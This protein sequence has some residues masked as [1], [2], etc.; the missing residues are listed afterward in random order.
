MRFTLTLPFGPSLG[1]ELLS[2]PAVSCIARAAEEA[3]FYAAGAVD[4]PIPSGAWLRAG[5][6]HSP[7]PTL[8][9]A[10][11]AAAT[12]ALRLQTTVYILPYRNPFLT[13][14]SVATLDQLSGGRLD[15]GVGIGYQE[16]E[17]RALGIEPAERFALF[18]EALRTMRAVWAHTTVSVTGRHFVAK[19]NGAE[20]APLQQPHP[21]LWIGGVS[22]WAL[23]RVVAHG[24]AWMAFTRERFSE[25]T[26]ARLEDGIARLREQCHEAGRAPMRISVNVLEPFHGEGRDAHLAILRRLAA[27][28]VTDVRVHVHEDTVAGWLARIEEHAT[29]IAAALT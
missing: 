15:L 28:G 26:F 14:K 2:A 3:G 10:V 19:D 22:P 1:P 23:R 18:D 29:T 13:A 24:E 5:G 25:A 16:P 7:E 27:M 6:H 21:P 17:M 4:H 20:P 9:L 11:A 12:T 8:M